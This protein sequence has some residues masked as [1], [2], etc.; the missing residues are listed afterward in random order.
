MTS[1]LMDQNNQTAPDHNKIKRNK[2]ELCITMR[3]SEDGGVNKRKSH[4]L[5]DSSEENGGEYLPTG[6]DDGSH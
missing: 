6:F 1:N 4:E 5:V 3:S 2:Y